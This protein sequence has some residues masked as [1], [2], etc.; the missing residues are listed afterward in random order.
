MNFL[1]SPLSRV[2]L[3]TIKQEAGKLKIQ[4]SHEWMTWFNSIYNLMPEDVHY[5]GATGEPAFENSWANV[6]GATDEPAGFYKDPFGR[7]YLIGL[8][9]TGS[10]G[11]VAFTLPEGYRPEYDVRAVCDTVSGGGGS[12]GHSGV[13]ISAAGAVTVTMSGTSTDVSLSNISFRA[14]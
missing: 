11:T 7:V 12:G 10:T 5:I 4:N 2:S 3:G 6:G 8:I 14:T 1:G 13:V 9:D